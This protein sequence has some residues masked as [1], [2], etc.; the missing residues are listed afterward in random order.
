[1]FAPSHENGKAFLTAEFSVH[2][3][4]L[5]ALMLSGEEA[6]LCGKDRLPG[7]WAMAWSGPSVTFFSM[8]PERPS[9]MT[10]CSGGLLLS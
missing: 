9:H 6:G 10:A 7:S 4:R 8:C 5:Q 1:M 2:M 3:Y